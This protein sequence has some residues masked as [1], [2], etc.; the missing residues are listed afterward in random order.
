MVHRLESDAPQAHSENVKR[1]DRMSGSARV[2]DIEDSFR[3][4]LRKSLTNLV[5]S[6]KEKAQW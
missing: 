4:S 6:M 3:L 1:S 5:G 2:R